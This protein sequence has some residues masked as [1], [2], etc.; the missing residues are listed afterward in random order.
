MP[1]AKRSRGINRDLLSKFLVAAVLGTVVV[2]GGAL[3]VTRLASASSAQPSG[4]PP[5]I[6]TDQTGVDVAVG[7]VPG[8]NPQPL[9]QLPANTTVQLASYDAAAQETTAPDGK[10]RAKWWNDSVP[11]IPAISQFDGSPLQGVNCVMA[12]GAM[13]ARLAY[14]IV[15]TGSQLR[16]LSRDTEGPTSL[17]DL[18]NA[19]YAGWGIKFNLGAATPLQ[20]RALMYAGA[21]AE[22]IV[23]YG[24]IPANVRLSPNFTGNHA[25]YIDAFRPAGVEGS[26]EDEYYV[27]D[28]IGHTWAGYK[29]KWWSA[30]VVERAAGVFGGGRIVTAWAFARGKVPFVHPV[31]PR[32]AYPPDMPPETPGP[33]ETVGPDGSAGP[34][35]DQ[36]PLGDLPIE[37]DTTVGTEP[38]DGPKFP[39]TD[40]F[41]DRFGLDTKLSASACAVIPAP[42]GCPTGIVGILGT[43]DVSGTSLPIKLLYADTIGPG[44]YQII[45]ESPTDSTSELLFWNSTTGGTLA[46]AKVESGLLS[47]KAVSIATITL[48]PAT[49]YS[50]VATSTSDGIRSVSDIGS[51]LV[52]P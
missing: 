9:G 52:Q 18:Q 36:M 16:A 38:P 19:V 51:L 2:V 12:S 24:A 31:L 47:D 8:D 42:R 35:V 49:S 46:P 3:L 14:G 37:V 30:T 40:F 33:G 17:Q 50:F 6:I 10:V 7:L 27:M 29:G 39:H 22:I 25:I 11:R 26:T 48:D 28:P 43:K 21:G 32:T 5:V 44:M 45:F 20:F 15:T 4:P 34:P 1:A 13:L 41:T 23:N